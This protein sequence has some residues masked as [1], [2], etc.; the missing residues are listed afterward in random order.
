[1]KLFL[2]GKKEEKPEHRE[3]P[4]EVRRVAE[5]LKKV[6]DPE[7]DLNI[8]E[9]GLVYG[10]TV[11]GKKAM[12]W[13]NFARSTPICKFCQ[14]IAITIQKRIVRDVISVLEKEGFNEVEIYNEIGLLLEKWG[15]E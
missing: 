15:K 6:K 10:L 7:T 13:L 1:M 9:E 3:L 4:P 5:L 8:V 12:I 11:E 14:P 2:R